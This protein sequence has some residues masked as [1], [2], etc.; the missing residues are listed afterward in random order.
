MTL[1]ILLSR[2]SESLGEIKKYISQF[3]SEGDALLRKLFFVEMNNLSKFG[4][5]IESLSS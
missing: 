3:S 4:K 1:A 5:F 2:L